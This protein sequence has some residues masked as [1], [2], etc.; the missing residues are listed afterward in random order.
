MPVTSAAGGQARRLLGGPGLEGNGRRRGARLR[1]DHHHG[2]GA[3]AVSDD[4][5]AMDGASL[6]GGVPGAE[7]VLA[8]VESEGEL[9]IEDDDEI[10]G[11]GCVHARAGVVISGHPQPLVVPAG[12]GQ[13]DQAP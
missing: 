8:F 4:P 9:A 3:G 7:E 1:P 5:P 11:V 10:Q 13:S 12:R 2:E 6:H